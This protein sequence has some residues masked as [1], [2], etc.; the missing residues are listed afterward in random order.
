MTDPPNEYEE[1]LLQDFD[2]GVRIV[3][4]RIERAKSVAELDEIRDGYAPAVLRKFRSIFGKGLAMEADE[5]MATAK[6]QMDQLIEER[7]A[8]LKPKAG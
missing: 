8:Q 4:A 6:D 1:W 5:R 3:A 2:L 7:A